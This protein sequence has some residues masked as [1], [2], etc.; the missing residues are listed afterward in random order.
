MLDD[1]LITRDAAER[2]L[3]PHLPLLAQ[4]LQAGW[5]AW[6]RLLTSDVAGPL[7]RSARARVVYDHATATAEHLFGPVPG[8]LTGRHHGLLILDFGRVLVRFKKLDSSL[9]AR[10]IPTEQQQMFAGQ[11]HVLGRPVQLTLFPAAPML[12]AGYVLDALESNMQRMVLVL[13]VH[14]HVVWELPL[15][16]V[17][18]VIPVV[19][20]EAPAATVRSLRRQEARREA[21]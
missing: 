1:M 7:S 11:E 5:Q 21:E 18:V 2:H 17:P 10:G 9:R 12:I 20:V 4:A 3:K 13:S 6:E 8:V 16:G 14:D 19:A 15:D